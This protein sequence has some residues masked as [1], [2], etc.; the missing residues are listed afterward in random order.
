[1]TPRLTLNLGLRYEYN[2]PPSERHDRMAIFNFATN[3][4]AQVGTNGAQILTPDRRD[5][6]PRVGIVWDPSGTGRTAIR[7]GAGIY[8]DVPLLSV[9]GSMAN[10]PPFATSFSYT[11]PG[12]PL[13]AHSCPDPL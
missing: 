12:I 3:S 5:F 2:S 1:M 13:A 6:G 7:S 11:Y 8:Y 9:A 4:L 10:N